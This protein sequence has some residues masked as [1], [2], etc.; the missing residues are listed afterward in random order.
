MQWCAI[1]PSVPACATSKA[2]MKSANI[3]AHARAHAPVPRLAAGV[4][5]R[6]P[7]RGVGRQHLVH[8]GWRQQRE[9]CVAGSTWEVLVCSNCINGVWQAAPGKSWVAA[10]CQAVGSVD[11]LHASIDKQCF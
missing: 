10:T 9:R 7:L 2:S 5:T 11:T 8:P 3:C 6:R 1:V 4:A